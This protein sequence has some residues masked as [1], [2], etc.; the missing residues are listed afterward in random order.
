MNKDDLKN[1]KYNQKWINGRL[2][3]IEDY[4]ARINKL[5]STLSDMP[6]GSRVVQDSEADKLAKLMDMVDELLEKVMKL[7]DKQREILK[8][9]EKVEQPYRLILEEMY[10]HNKSLVQIANDMHYS[11]EHAK[12]MNGIALKKFEDVT[13]CY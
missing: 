8:Q 11:Y 12:R 7:N 2:E 9:L 3:Y 1:Y 10:I 4:K 5:T 6:K 13:K